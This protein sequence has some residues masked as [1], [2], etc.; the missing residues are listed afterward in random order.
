[1]ARPALDLK[2]RQL[3]TVAALTALAN[4]APQLRYHIEGALNVGWKPL[5]V[6]EVIMLSTVYAGFPAA[7]NGVFAAKEVFERRGL[8]PDVAAS[9]SSNDRHE[10]GLSSL[11]AVSGNSGAGV[12]QALAQIAPDLGG[13][14]V[15][16]SYGEVI[17]RPTL[18]YRTKE[19]ATVALLTALGT[20]AP[21]LKV[22]IGAALNV[23]A[24]REKV[25]EVIQ[26]MAV[27][28]GFPAALN[29]VTAAREV[30]SAAPALD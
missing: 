12:V 10:R 16:F 26:Q 30:F 22:H 5:E 7:L 1:M 9:A 8:M 29:G 24:T 15:D 17:S 6:V 27:Y 20:A 11:Q 19:L 18:D 3:A 4:A 14:I 28:A 21:Q 23:G 13:F 2:T 25:V